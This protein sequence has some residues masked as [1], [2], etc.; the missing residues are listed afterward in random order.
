MPYFILQESQKDKIHQW[1]CERLSA[2]LGFKMSFED[3]RHNEHGKPFLKNHPIHFNLSHSHEYAILAIA[4]S[5]IGVDIEK[6]RDTLDVSKMA[7]RFF[8]ENEKNI[9]GNDR[10]KF[11]EYWVRKE[12]LMKAV[13]DGIRMGF[14]AVDVS[15]DVVSYE[16]ES[17]KIKNL[18]LDFSGY[19]AALCQKCF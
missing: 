1:M 5:P 19:K 10:E 4:E 3:V 8:C 7:G 13:G 11:F 14:D 15:E 17:W 18:H 6:I 9:I 16:G 12:A 2:A